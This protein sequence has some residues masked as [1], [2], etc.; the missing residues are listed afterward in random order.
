MQTEP[1]IF[2]PVILRKFELVILNVS[3]TSLDY[4]DTVSKFSVLWVPQEIIPR[5]NGIFSIF[6]KW[7]HDLLL[8]FDK[9]HFT[10]NCSISKHLNSLLLGNN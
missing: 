5:L 9:I 10:L 6:V 1:T 4:N 3:Y 7:H 8:T 2:Y